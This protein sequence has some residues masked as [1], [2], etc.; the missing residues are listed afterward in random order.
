MIMIGSGCQSMSCVV[1]IGVSANVNVFLCDE[2]TLCLS[3]S[4][5]KTSDDLLKYPNRT[6]RR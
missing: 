4:R 2:E 1:E 6:P 5:I 3:S